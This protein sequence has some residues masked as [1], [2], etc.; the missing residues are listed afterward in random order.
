MIRHRR[1]LIGRRAALPLLLAPVLGLAACGQGSDSGDAAESTLTVCTD[2]PFPP[3]EFPDK[4]APSGFSGFEIDLVQ[5]IADNL[6]M[7]LVVNDVGFDALQSGAAIRAGQ[8]E[9]VAAAIVPT[10]AREKNL[11]FSDPFFK[12]TFAILAPAGSDVAAMDDLSGRT[13]AV[14]QGSTDATYLKE[15]APNDAGITMFSD[16]NDMW[17]ALQA[18]SVDAMFQDAL[19]ANEHATKNPDYAVT[20]TFEG[21]DLSF[22]VLRSNTTLLNDIN[23]ALATTRKDGTYDELTKEYIPKKYIPDDAQ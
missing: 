6:D 15:N 21:L 14:Q 13:I 17:L 9:M 11:A 19:V 2:S 12:T 8:C 22:G 20:G 23:E 10:P 1:N 16:E 3:F 18:G 4:N 7:K 5:A